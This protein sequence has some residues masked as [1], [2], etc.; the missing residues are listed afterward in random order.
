MI[1]SSASAILGR[2][3]AGLD[4]EHAGVGEVAAGA[5]AEV[6]PPA[7]EVVEQHDP[8]GDHQR[9][10]VGEAHHAGPEADVAR[11]L[12]RHGQEQLRRGD[13]LP[14]GAVVLADPGLVEAEP[15]EEH[16]QLEVALERQRRVLPR[17]VVRG[18]EDA[19]AHAHDAH[20]RCRDTA[21]M[22][23]RAALTRRPAGRPDAPRPPRPAPC[24]A[25][26]GC[27]IL[28]PGNVWNARVDAPAGAAGLRRADRRHRA[29]RRPPPGLQRRGRLRHPRQR[30]R[31]PDA[32]TGGAL[33]VRQRVGPG[34][35]PDPGAAADR[36][37]LGPP[38]PDGRP[39]RLPA[40]RAVRRPAGAPAA[41]GARAR[42]P[43]ST[44]ART[45]C[46]PAGWTSADA[47]GLP[48]LPGLARYE[49]AGGRRHRPRPALHR[50]AHA[51][52]A[53]STPRATPPA[54]APTRRCRP[55]ACA[56]G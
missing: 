43:S 3:Q 47:A 22:P 49:R 27:P 1:T 36:G 30:G 34:A 5:D 12:G 10:V 29:G 33:P 37:R 6:Q 52:R 48:I 35:L 56:C 18:E 14:A 26:A 15:V 17:L 42:A 24:R 44:C 39:R 23:R 25:R 45:G 41:R 55:W 46:G 4:A 40:L 8:V 53:S 54:R 31:P 13:R 9:V 51:Q 28:P 7:G 38:P 2:R 32:A 16:D 20:S 50:A 21:P 19:E 11:P